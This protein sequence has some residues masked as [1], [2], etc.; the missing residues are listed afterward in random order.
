[1]QVIWGA[2]LGMWPRSLIPSQAPDAHASMFPGAPVYHD[3]TYLLADLGVFTL[4][5]NLLQ[6]RDAGSG[7]EELYIG[8]LTCM[9]PLV[10]HSEQP[11]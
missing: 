9:F 2:G 7:R 11:C 1:M 5:D 4:P 6:Y 10:G 3:P 8:E